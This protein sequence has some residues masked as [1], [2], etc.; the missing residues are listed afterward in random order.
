M[1][2][3]WIRTCYVGFH[4]VGNSNHGNSF[5]HQLLHFLCH[6]SCY[7]IMTASILTSWRDSVSKWDHVF[8]KKSIRYFFLKR[9]RGRHKWGK[10]AFKNGRRCSRVMQICLA[11]VTLGSPG[12]AS[13][14]SHLTWR[15][16]IKSNEEHQPRNLKKHKKKETQTRKESRICYRL[17]PSRNTELLLA[18]PVRPKVLKYRLGRVYQ[19]STEESWKGSEQPI[20]SW[21]RGTARKRAMRKKKPDNN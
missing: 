8:L 21:N 4:T 14:R 9:I 11:A 6:L 13:T 17:N 16:G 19:N 10:K 3:T 7:G 5:S 1:A 20:S 18:R 12:Y 2:T 15:G